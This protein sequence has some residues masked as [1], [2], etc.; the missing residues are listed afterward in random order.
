VRALEQVGPGV[1][2]VQSYVT[3]DKLYC[4]YLAPDE[5]AIH[6]HARISGSSA[7]KISPV[8]STNRPDI[9]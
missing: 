1:Q 3:D 7:T 8:R 5:T 6:E 4:I 9:G 2:R